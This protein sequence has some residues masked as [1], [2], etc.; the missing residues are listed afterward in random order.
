MLT[1]D[2]P[3][4]IRRITGSGNSSVSPTFAEHNAKGA[5]DMI[6]PKPA[7]PSRGSGFDINIHEEMK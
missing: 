2:N 4:A 6:H 7:A 5:R 1:L 3:F